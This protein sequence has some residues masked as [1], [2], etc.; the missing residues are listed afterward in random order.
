M[1]IVVHSPKYGSEQ[2]NKVVQSFTVEI[3]FSMIDKEKPW[4]VKDR[5]K[6]AIGAMAKDLY[7]VKIPNLAEKDENLN[8]EGGKK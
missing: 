5:P 3:Q 7:D 1:L 8:K 4:K 6:I 2:M